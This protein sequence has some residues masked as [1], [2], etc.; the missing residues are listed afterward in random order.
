MAHDLVGY[1]VCEWFGKVCLPVLSIA[2]VTV[3]AGLL[4]RLSLDPSFL[5]VVATTAC[6]EAVF[7]P[8]IWFLVLDDAERSYLRVRIDSKLPKFGGSKRREGGMEE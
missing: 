2:A 7:L 5:R 3:V 8:A 1:S 6:C 4:P